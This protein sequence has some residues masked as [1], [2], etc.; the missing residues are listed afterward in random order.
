MILSLSLYDEWR[1]D[2]KGQGKVRSI[3]K[4]RG[5]FAIFAPKGSTMARYLERAKGK[6]MSMKRA[7]SRLLL[8]LLGVATSAGLVLGGKAVVDSVA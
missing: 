7:S 5:F 4:M 2:G 1:T 8:G 3:V 6:G